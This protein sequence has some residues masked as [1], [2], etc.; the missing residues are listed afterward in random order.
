[1]VTSTG[2]PEPIIRREDVRRAVNG[3]RSRPLFIIDIAVP[4]DVDAGV[5]DLDGVFSYDIDDLRQVVEANFR[6]R[7]RGAQ[8]AELL[9]EREVEKFR[10]QLRNLE[11]A[12]AIASLRQKLE[13]IR[14]GEVARAMA[15]LPG[16][17]PELRA[18][19][20]AMSSAIVNKVLH[21]PTEKLRESS[22][23]GR[24]RRW[25]ILVSELFGLGETGDARSN[26]TGGD[27]WKARQAGMDA[28][29]S[30]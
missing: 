16:A 15:R 12:P 29:E 18:T 19:I 8:Q 23:N 26:P 17:A 6:E 21:P 7:L 27:R 24:G 30:R 14:Q 1:V 22:R 13:A 25:T 11:V 20:E 10:S 28:A 9:V 2:A 3:R 4:R 5:D